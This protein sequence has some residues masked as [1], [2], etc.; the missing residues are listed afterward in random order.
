[1]FACI[2]ARKLVGEVSPDP[3]V[4]IHPLADFAYSYSPIVEATFKET[5]VIDVDGCN[6]RF[7][8]PYALANQIAND[9]QQKPP[10]GLETKVN[11]ALA[12]NPDAAVF[13]A[14]HLNGVTFIARG[15]ELTAIGDLPIDCLFSKSKV[16]GSTSK[17][18]DKKPLRTLDIGHWT[19]DFERAA[20]EILETLRVWGVRT[21]KEFAALPVSGVSERLGQTGLKLQKLASGQNQRHLKLRQHAPQFNDKIELDY[22][23]SELEP[24]A[25][26]LGRLLNHIC[27]NLNAYALATNA[28]HVQL[29]L[30]GGPVHEINLNLPYPM[31]DHKVFLKLLLLDIEMHSPPAAVV[32]VTINCEPVPPRVLQSGLFIPLA[33]EPEKLEL[34]LAR[35]AK[36]VGKENIGSPELIDTH[37]PDAFRVNRFELKAK[38]RR[39][40]RTRKEE[41]AKDFQPKT[42]L[43]FRMFRPP[44]RAIVNVLQGRPQEISAWDKHKSVYGKIVG[45]AGPWR[46]T[47]DWWRTDNWARDEWDVAVEKGSVRQTLVCRS[48]KQGMESM[49]EPPAVL[50][51]IYREL[52]SDV[53]FVEGVYD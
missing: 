16:Q 29:K 44:L 1:M 3:D 14:C 41:K 45:V 6:L 53:W 47:G 23:L 26:I 12:A 51:R 2:H 19:L 37:R 13:A 31:R 9:A 48:D 38:N 7:G 24:L 39:R 34:L 4:E 17:G 27:A 5:V 49:S 25:F 32:G 42:V 35:L 11:V 50:Y 43:G 46:T 33:P 8:S 15:E 10:V 20:E 22:P 52:K 28:L 21:F 40:W 30:A 18:T 36:L